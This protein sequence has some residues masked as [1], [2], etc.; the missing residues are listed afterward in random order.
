MILEQSRCNF[1]LC[2]VATCTAR[3]YSRIS[4]HESQMWLTLWFEIT[5]MTLT[6]LLL[7]MNVTQSTLWKLVH[8]NLIFTFCHLCSTHFFYSSTI[9]VITWWMI[10]WLRFLVP[11]CVQEWLKSKRYWREWE[12]GV[13]WQQRDAWT[14][15]Q[16]P[17]LPLE[18]WVFSECLLLVG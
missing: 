13:C 4:A 1:K 14:M 3:A 17:E 18:L 2:A 9:F 6:L 8:N 5:Y 7:N 10:K 12:K 16:G 11:K 15:S